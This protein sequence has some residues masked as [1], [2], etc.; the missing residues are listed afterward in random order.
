MA[1]GGSIQVKVVAKSSQATNEVNKFKESL[2]K[3]TPAM[4]KQELG[5]AKLARS[6]GKMLKMRIIRQAVKKLIG[7]IGEGVKSLYEWDNALG[8]SFSKSLDAYA[9]ASQNIKNSMGVA[10]APIIEML[11]PLFEK[12]SNVIMKAANAISRF[13]AI[14]NGQSQYR[15]VIAT[16]TKF[17]SSTGDANKN[18][19]E[20]KRTLL[21]F[22]ELNLLNSPSSGSG[23]GSGGSGSDFSDAFKMEDVGLDTGKLGDR[24][25]LG[26]KKAV[27]TVKANMP[28]FEDALGNFEFGIGAILAF[29]G[30]PLLGIGLMAAGA[31]HKWKASKSDWG[32]LNDKVVGTVTSLEA[33]LG[34][35]MLGIGAALAFSSVNIPLGLALMAGG[36]FAV[37]GLSL[38][39]NKLSSEVQAQV[40]KIMLIV[41]GALI[42]IGILLCANPATMPLG[43][44]LIAAGA[45]GIATAIKLNWD[46]ITNKIDNA[47]TRAGNAVHKFIQPI[48]TLLNRLHQVF[49]RSWSL[50]LNSMGSPLSGGL[51]GGIAMRA[52]GGTVPTGQMFMARESGPELV[53]TIGGQTAVLNNDQIVSAVSDGVYRAVSAAMGSRGDTQVRVYLDSREIKTG[54]QRLARANG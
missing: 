35:A 46:T 10:F 26:I 27:D 5:I 45:V 40:T 25:A 49:D 3:L 38:N 11:V 42:A 23:G 15:K 47:M 18:L 51:G 54:Q 39:W 53:G 28:V 4:A 19:K 36:T 2:Q 16:T 14:I 34:L 6:F 21:G 31:M 32:G 22:D 30:H 50:R 24:I 17:A 52:S 13:F 37:G 8:G 33:G 12:L 44:G 1:D 7:S 43:V 9:S 48:E 29:S 41:S 20:M